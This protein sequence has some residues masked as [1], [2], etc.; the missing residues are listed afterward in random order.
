MILEILLLAVIKT[1]PG[2]AQ[3]GIAQEFPL[4]HSADQRYFLNA[5]GSPRPIL[6]R[7]SWSL[8]SLGVS[9]YQ[10][11]LQDTITR[12]FNTIEMW[13]IYHWPVTQV[14]GAPTPPFAGNGSLPFLKRLDGASWSGALTYTNINNEGPDF[15]TP[16]QTYFDY[17]KTL[18][19]YANNNGLYVLLFPSYV[20]Y[21]G[22][23]QGWG[24]EVVANGQTKMQTFGAYIANEFKNHTG[25]MWMLGGDK[26][27]SPNAFSTAENNA[28]RGQVDGLKSVSG[29]SSL[30]YGAE[31]EGSTTDNYSYGPEQTAVGS[32]LTVHG[33]YSWVGQQGK[34]GRDAYAASPTLPAYYMEGPYD[35]EG[36]EDINFNPNAIQPT[37]RFNWNGVLNTIGGYVNGNGHVWPFG[38]GYLSHLNDVGTQQCSYLNFFI[39]S[40]PWHRLVPSG[41]GSMGTL[42]T[43][44]A[45]TIDATSYVASACTPLGDILIA[46]CNP[47][48][49]NPT[50]DMTKLRGTVTARWFDPTAGTYTTIGSFSNTG[51][52]QFTKPGNNSAGTGDWV[53]RLDA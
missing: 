20:G 29:Q 40:I 38:S 44:G 15:T 6:G 16:N 19:S 31:W 18:V 14:A 11:Y 49:G 32:E 3:G 4:T 12:G 48:S 7:T 21:T 30:E 34:G 45:G 41:L 37:R 39:R 25:V 23:N 22:T 33:L 26:G 42:V 53:L 13:A 17:L 2:L 46:Y 52:H 36:P 9:A 10:S 8:I 51:T 27:T 1:I 50:I 43:A 35:R 24:L 28:Q 47:S 5:S